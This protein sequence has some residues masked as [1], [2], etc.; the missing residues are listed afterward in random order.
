MSKDML[1]IL[2]AI[3]SLMVASY[4]LYGILFNYKHHEEIIQHQCGHYNDVT[5]DF[6]WKK[7]TND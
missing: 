3:T 7:E 6:E 4:N 1:A 2:I 5:G